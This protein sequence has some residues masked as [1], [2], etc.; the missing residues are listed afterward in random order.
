MSA[1]VRF[2]FNFLIIFIIFYGFNIGY[3]AIINPGGLYFQFLDE[4]CNYIELWRNLY[5]ST[6]AKIL[7]L[8]GYTVH[9]TAIS[10]KVKDHSGFRLVY[11]CLGYGIMSF[12]SAFVLSFPKP[13]SSRIIFLFAGLIIILTL[14]LCRFIFIPLFYNPQITLLSANHHDIFN[15]ILYLILLFMIYKWVNI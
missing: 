8:M 2:L 10:L 12:F 5:I 1:R 11:S 15:G 9:T 7:E 13:F 14:N 4:H 6:A 3:I